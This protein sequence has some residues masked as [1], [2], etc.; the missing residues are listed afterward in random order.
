MRTQN[1]LLAMTA[2]ARGHEL[3]AKDQALLSGQDATAAEQFAAGVEAAI[4]WALGNIGSIPFPTAE[5]V[6]P[7]GN[8]PDDQVDAILADLPGLNGR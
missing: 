4:L 2:T 5:H 3:R 8:G 7:T 6:K 1:E